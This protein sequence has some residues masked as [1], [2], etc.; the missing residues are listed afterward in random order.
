MRLSTLG[1]SPTVHPADPRSWSGS[2]DRPCSGRWVAGFPADRMWMLG[3]C[4]VVGG[5]G[6]LAGLFW[7]SIGVAAAASSVAHLVAA[8]AFHLESRSVDRPMNGV[9]VLTALS[10][11]PWYCAR[12]VGGRASARWVARC[13]RSAHLLTKFLCDACQRRRDPLG[14]SCVGA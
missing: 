9:I 6:L 3:V 13:R 10:V 2:R 5:I 4:T 7:W 14:P 11:A 12:R 8:L 1:R